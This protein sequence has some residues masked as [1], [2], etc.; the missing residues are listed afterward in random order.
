MESDPSCAFAMA[1]LA[2]RT[3]PFLHRG[4]DSRHGTKSRRCA[5]DR[6][7]I[8]YTMYINAVLKRFFFAPIAVAPLLAELGV[9]AMLKAENDR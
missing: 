2:A 8:T 5:I 3:D 1:D 6:Y 4:R 7:D 9:F